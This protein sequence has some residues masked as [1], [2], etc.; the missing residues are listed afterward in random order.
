MASAKG[1][2]MNSAKGQSMTSAGSV[3]PKGEYGSQATMTTS[4]RLPVTSQG[5]MECKNTLGQMSAKLR[6]DGSCHTGP[7]K[8]RHS[9][10]P[11]DR[12]AWVRENKQYNPYSYFEASNNPPPPKSKKKLPTELWL[13]ERSK[14]SSKVRSMRAS[15]SASLGKGEKSKETEDEDSGLAGRHKSDPSKTS[16]ATSLSDRPRWDTEHAV[17]FSRMNHEVQV[18][19]REYFDKPKDAETGV[20]KE[21][22]RHCQHDRVVGWNDE[23]DELGEGRR[24]LFNTIGPYN[25]GGCKTQQLP[26]YWRKVQNWQAFSAPDLALEAGISGTRSPVKGDR[27]LL[28]ALADTPAKQSKE[29]WRGYSATLPKQPHAHPRERPPRGWDNRWNVSWSKDNDIMNQCMREYFSVTDGK[30]GLSTEG[31]RP[32]K[33]KDDPYA[34]PQ[35]FKF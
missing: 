33:H 8:L 29:F 27:S 30:P 32:S 26:S 28:A 15:R 31:P 10:A 1:Q 19:V 18:G 20:I 12:T 16:A 13:P 21:H 35:V 14:D 3:S 25:L 9:L 23:P 4:S 34:Q 11:P 5:M 6:G 7:L 17:T 2:S 24:T 22:V